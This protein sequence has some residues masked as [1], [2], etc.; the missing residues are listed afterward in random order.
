MPQTPS[1]FR[2]SYKMVVKKVLWEK[3]VMKSF[4]IVMLRYLRGLAM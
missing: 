2:I 4:L 1:T 3:G